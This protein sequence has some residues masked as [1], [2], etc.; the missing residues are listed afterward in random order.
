MRLS[1]WGG[2]H[3]AGSKAH[4][5]LGNVLFPGRHTWRTVGQASQ[6]YSSQQ[7]NVSSYAQ[8]G[9]SSAAP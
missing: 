4:G 2:S 7:I 6:L 3:L 1:H 9:V 8:L 5:V